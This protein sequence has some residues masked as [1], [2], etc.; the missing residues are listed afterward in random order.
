MKKWY[1]IYALLLVLPLRLVAQSDED[2]LRY[3]TLDFGGTARSWGSANAYGAVGGDFS[4]LSMNP[5]GLGIYRS[6]ELFFGMGL[7]F[8][9]NRS[10][11]YD[12]YQDRDRDNF[13]VSG[14]G[15]VLTNMYKGRENST[16]N[17]VSTNFGFGYNRLANYN[18]EINYSGF[19][20]ANS[21][22]DDYVSQL[23]ANGGTTPSNVYNSAPF[24]AGLAWE[25][26][27]LNPYPSDTTQYSS[28]IQ[29][30]NVQ[31]SKYIQ[32]SGGYDEMVL[33]F[34]GNYGNKLYIG[35][36]MGMPIVNYNYSSI[37][38]EADVNNVH[39]DFNSFDL[40][41]NTDAHGF[42]INGKFGF[43][44]R[45][46]NYVRIGGAVHTPTYIDMHERYYSS[47]NS[48]L[49]MTGSYYYESPYGEYLYGLTTPWRLFG[50]AAVTIQKYGFLS[51]D[52]EF[53]DYGEAH[54]NFNRIGS[55]S[56]INYEN[57]LNNT[58]NGKY[59]GAHNFRFGAEASIDIFRLRGGYAIQATPFNSG[60]ATGNAD[61][62]KNTFTA[63]FGIKERS[64]FVDFAYVNS[65]STEYDQEY[66]SD[67]NGGNS[68]A[69]IDKRFSNF[70]MSFGFRF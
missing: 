41:N 8:I 23:N 34:A 70:L 6:S 68:G 47:M 64:Y 65:S 62:A 16:N 55:G 60:V 32:T 50:S 42:G 33:S 28:V 48:Q 63:G 51:F 46:S 35:A 56:D 40:V 37:Y 1:T 27:M 59:T 44:Y 24:G 21:L 20:N 19:N 58:I 3:S 17:W 2:A 12:N 69:T 7:A 67:V 43:I 31:Q 11:M 9:N 26:Y 25:T 29:D 14:A 18:S 54:Y 49:D 5:A 22:L 36:T 61:Y 15:M 57:N 13:H 66:Y 39:D 4:T 38:S 45:I 10:E 30:G 52:Y 53:V